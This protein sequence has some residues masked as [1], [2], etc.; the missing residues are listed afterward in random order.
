M[1]D[2]RVQHTLRVSVLNALLDRRRP[3]TSG[4]P[5]KVDCFEE[6]RLALPVLSQEEVRSGT[7]FDFL[8]GEI[9]EPG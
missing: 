6:I 8:T 2:F 7:E 4:V 1:P 3:E 9:A 5:E